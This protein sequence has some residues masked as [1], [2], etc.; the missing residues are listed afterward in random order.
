MDKWKR[1]TFDVTKASDDR[2]AT[3]LLTMKG[4]GFDR[5]SIGYEGKKK[6]YIFWKSIP[7]K[8]KLKKVV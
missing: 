7:V 2:R 6:Y 3:I 1:K 8:R 5:F 4:K